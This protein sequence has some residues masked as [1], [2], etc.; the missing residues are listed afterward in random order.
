MTEQNIEP[1]T[2]PSHQSY[3]AG[4]AYGKKHP[5]HTWGMAHGWALRKNI[6]DLDAFADG[7]ADGQARAARG[8]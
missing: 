4:V 7:I 6:E 5:D 3:V 2:H 8:A 1:H